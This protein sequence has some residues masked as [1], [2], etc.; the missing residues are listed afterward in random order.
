MSY[1]AYIEEAGDEGLGRGSRWFIVGAVIVEESKDLTVSHCIDHIKHELGLELS[2]PVHWRNIKH[3]SMRRW[4]IDCL[5]KEDFTIS[6]VICDTYDDTIK[7]STLKGNGRLYAYVI[8]Y[9]ME[10]ISW[11]GHDRGQ[12][13]DLVFAN[14]SNVSYDELK[15]YL[16]R[17]QKD[18][19]CQIKSGVIDVSR[20]QC[21]AV[22][23][24]KLLQ[25][26]DICNGACFNALE[27]DR[28]GYYDERYLLG[29]W[30]KIYRRNGNLFSYG[31]KFLPSGLHL[32]TEMKESYPWLRCT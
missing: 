15:D 26:S 4:I 2:A 10:R 18:S 30:D 9:L 23:Q 5:R 28:F 32:K 17:I 1:V 29:L 7:A 19:S 21:K 13:V 8:R 24:V 6:Y 31:M 12:P 11:F 14:R 22:E 27:Y 3:P 25:V 16:N 20:M